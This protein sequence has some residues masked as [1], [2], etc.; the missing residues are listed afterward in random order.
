MLFNENCMFLPILEKFSKKISQ[1]YTLIRKPQKKGRYFGHKIRI[2]F[3]YDE[4]TK[5][6]SSHKTQS[7]IHMARKTS[8]Y[9]FYTCY[10]SLCRCTTTKIVIKA[11]ISDK[12]NFMFAQRKI[13]DVWLK[14]RA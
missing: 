13:M 4:N 2:F 1:C 8:S 6:N 12:N 14:E 11:V 7:Q 5:T 3:F 10:T 9:V